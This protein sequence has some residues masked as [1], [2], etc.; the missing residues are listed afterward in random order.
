M[1]TATS[2]QI[3]DA[4]VSSSFDQLDALRTSA[5]TGATMV[6]LTMGLTRNATTADWFKANSAPI[7]GPWKA[8]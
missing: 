3:Q 5:L 7:F 1:V 8:R 6:G 4:E 2:E